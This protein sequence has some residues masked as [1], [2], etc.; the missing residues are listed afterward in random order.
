MQQV[1]LETFFRIMRS[2]ADI[3]MDRLKREQGD[4]VTQD[5]YLK[6]NSVQCHYSHSYK[7]RSSFSTCFDIF[8]FQRTLLYV[9]ILLRI[10]Q[11]RNKETNQ[12]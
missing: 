12:V 2:F 7:Y 6:S 10:R 8:R 3:C 1:P 9:V 11:M 5:A 4:F